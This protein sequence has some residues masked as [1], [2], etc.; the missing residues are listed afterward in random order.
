MGMVMAANVVPPMLAAK[1]STDYFVPENATKRQSRGTVPEN[2]GMYSCGIQEADRPELTPE[3]C[4]EVFG[5]L[6]L[7]SLESWPADEQEKVVEL[8]FVHLE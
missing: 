7:E 2:V 1:M 3:R 6:D 4:S 5:S 8:P